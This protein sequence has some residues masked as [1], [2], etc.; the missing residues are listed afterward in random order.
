MTQH[1]NL[2]KSDRFL[3]PAPPPPGQKKTNWIQK[4][5][6]PTPQTEKN[7][8][9][10]IYFLFFSPPLRQQI[11]R[12]TARQKQ[13][14]WQISVFFL[15][16]P[17][18]FRP[19]SLKNSLKCLNNVVTIGIEFYSRKTN[20]H[21]TFFVCKTRC[22]NVLSNKGTWGF[23]WRFV[24]FS[25]GDVLYLASIRLL[26][27]WNMTIKIHYLS[28]ETSNSLVRAYYMHGNS[29]S[30]HVLAFLT[31][32]STTQCLWELYRTLATPL[33]RALEGNVERGPKG[34]LP[35]HLLWREND[36]V[37]PPYELSWALDA[38]PLYKLLSTVSIYYRLSSPLPID[39]V[40]LRE[41]TGNR[42]L[43]TVDRNMSW[44]HYLT[45]GEPKRNNCLWR[46]KGGWFLSQYEDVYLSIGKCM[47]LYI[48]TRK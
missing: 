9:S 45:G 15:F 4:T 17:V 16:P 25:T 29:R 6:K 13:P 38:L 24:F 44:I 34:A 43:T 32:E 14:H 26:Q 42:S 18:L 39:T 40:N 7:K 47:K 28:P 3:G 20:F 21:M 22:I 12:I 37:S 41:L 11:T 35:S 5:P 31:I 8:F 48:Y 30:A 27:T 33:Q 1:R 36:V 46:A 23:L 2:K 10:Q 19:R